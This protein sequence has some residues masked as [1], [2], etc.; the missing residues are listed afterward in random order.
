MRLAFSPNSID[1]SRLFHLHFYLNCPATFALKPSGSIA[2]CKSHF[3]IQP[4]PSHCSIHWMTSSI[5]TF[6]MFMLI[7][8]I[9]WM[10]AIFRT[11]NTFPQILNCECLYVLL[12]N[13]LIPWVYH[14]LCLHPD[15]STSDIKHSYVCS[16]TSNTCPLTLILGNHI[17]PALWSISFLLLMP[18]PANLD[19]II[20]HFTVSL[21]STWDHLLHNLFS[22]IEKAPPMDF[23]KSRA[24]PS[25]WEREKIPYV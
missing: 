8:I 23:S 1:T 21:D 24:S 15:C 2:L 5:F 4:T 10:T 17:L 7:P 6:V 3:C 25:C 14:R 12:D 19:L 20:Y 18:F 22:P 9:P 11:L 13:Q 16:V